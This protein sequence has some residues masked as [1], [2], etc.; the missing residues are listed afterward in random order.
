MCVSKKR[1]EVEG[2]GG[3]IKKRDGQKKNIQRK[4]GRIQ[5]QVHIG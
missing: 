1:G 3:Q 4:M 2:G 5:F